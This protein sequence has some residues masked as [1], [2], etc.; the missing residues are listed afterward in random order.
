MKKF[1]SFGILFLMFFSF[2][3]F[4][5]FSEE[6]RNMGKWQTIIEGKTGQGSSFFIFNFK[7]NN[8]VEITK[9]YSGN[10]ITEEQNYTFDG[11]KILITPKD[12]SQILD[13]K[14]KTIEKLDENN[15]LW[16]YEGNQ[17]KVTKNHGAFSLIHLFGV[18]IVLIGINELSRKYKKLSYV[19][20]FIIPIVFIP[21]F[22]NSGI[23]HWFRWV[24]LYSAILGA[25]WFTLIR[26]TKLGEKNWAK[27]IAAAILCL[28]IA[29][30]CTQDFSMGYLPNVL[31]AIGGV[32]NI[33]V[34][35][36]WKG[37]GPDA[38]KD[39]DMVW[40]G[41]TTFWIIA[42]DIW[43]ITFVYLNFPEHAAY[44]IMVLLSCTIPALFIKK[45]TWLQARA[46]T[47]ASWMMYLFIFEGFINANVVALPRNNTL[48]LAMGALSFVAN[49]VYA[50]YHFRWFFFKKAPKNLE[51]GQNELA[52]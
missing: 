32:L 48:M 30:A 36:R 41:M 10:N 20:Y 24:K 25:A 16:D 35:S 40:P 50:F 17:L 1:K 46:F 52:Y 29:E 31:N 14:D 39:R 47:L 7:D 42:Y 5:L 33:I 26:F 13:F 22:I 21:I 15:F 49:V 19:L 8:V 18:I 45:G 6:N 38:T 23:T 2:F 51:V 43:N 9:Q 27:Y 28:N 37:I 11:N 34:L 44:H 12:S 3:S 4:S